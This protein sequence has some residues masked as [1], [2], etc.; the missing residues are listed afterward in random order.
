MAGRIDLDV[1]KTGHELF[2]PLNLFLS[3]NIRDRP[4]AMKRME[5]HYTGQSPAFGVR[6]RL[7][8]D[9][10]IMIAPDD[11]MTLHKEWGSVMVFS[12]EDVEIPP[13][14]K[15]VDLS[16]VDCETLMDIQLPPNVDGISFTLLHTN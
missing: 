3:Q 5:I 7:F 1:T 4:C 11:D 12:L 13:N 9:H 16:F 14:E 2:D 8:R 6:L 10:V 15:I